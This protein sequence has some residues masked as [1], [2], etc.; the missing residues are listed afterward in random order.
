PVVSRARSRL[1]TAPFV[2]RLCALGALGA[3]ASG[4]IGVRQ[5]P[6]EAGEGGASGPVKAST[7]LKTCSKT[8]PADDGLIHDFEDG[9]R[10]LLKV[11]GRD[12]YWWKHADDKGAKFEPDEILIEDGGPGESTKALHVS[13]ETVGGEGAYGTLVGVNYASSGLYDGSVYVGISFMAKVDPDSLKKVQF[14]V[15]DVNTHGDAGVCKTCWNHFNKD[16]VLTTEW[17]EYKVLF[18]D[19]RQE[20]GWGDPRPPALNTE[21]LF[22][23]DFAFAPAGKFGLWL[24]DLNFLVCE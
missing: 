18:A 11:A 20:A 22:S 24:D 6:S 12:G 15:G 2:A 9:D 3:L 8:K 4:C 19:M 16:I 21:Q 5:P 7:K 23:L 14:E 1:T 13:G 10:Q 17:K